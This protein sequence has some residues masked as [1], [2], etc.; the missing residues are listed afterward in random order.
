MNR[1]KFV[2]KS[3]SEVGPMTQFPM[4]CT[5][6]QVAEIFYRV[7][8]AKFSHVKVDWTHLTRSIYPKNTGQGNWDTDRYSYAYISHNISLGAGTPPAAGISSHT[9]QAPPSSYGSVSTTIYTQH[10]GISYTRASP[11]Y[12]EVEDSDGNFVTTFTGWSDLPDCGPGRRNMYDSNVSEFFGAPTEIVDAFII[13]LD[14][15]YE[16]R[17]YRES[18][19]ELGIWSYSASGGVRCYDTECGLNISISVGNRGGYALLDASAPA[20]KYVVYDKRGTA[21]SGYYREDDFDMSQVSYETLAVYTGFDIPPEVAYTGSAP[22]A[23]DAKLYILP[24]LVVDAGEFHPH[25][26]HLSTVW[27][28]GRTENA[29]KFSSEV[30]GELNVKLSNS[31]LSCPLYFITSQMIAHAPPLKLLGV[32]LSGSAYVTIEATDWWPYGGAWDPATGLRAA[33]PSY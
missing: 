31:Q 10:G 28:A 18:N 11:I 25:Q 33:P 1:V 27:A 19:S 32:T 6:D 29:I 13:S 2:K 16:K 7:R 15:S 4:E 21:F 5:L 20:N 24:S 26:R 3:P 22:W 14:S 9:L 17:V 23:A 8:K 12:A 30:A